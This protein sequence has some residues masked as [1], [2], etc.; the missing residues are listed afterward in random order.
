MSTSLVYGA[1]SAEASDSDFGETSESSV[2]VLL[3]L[4]GEFW[5]LFDVLPHCSMKQT[6]S[7]LHPRTPNKARQGKHFVKRRIVIKIYTTRRSKAA[8]AVVAVGSLVPGITITV[9]PVIPPPIHPSTPSI[10]PPT[11]PAGGQL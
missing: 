10:N 11:S 4:C 1:P 8:V 7:F 2:Y 3:S 9:F 5:S 6:H